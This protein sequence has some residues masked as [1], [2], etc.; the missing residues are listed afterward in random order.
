MYIEVGIVYIIGIM[1]FGVALYYVF[2]KKPV[3]IYNQMKPPLSTE[4]TDVKKYNH[5]TA[6]LM[7]AYGCVFIIEGIILSSEPMTCMVVGILTVMPG[8]VIVIAIYET[9]VIKKYKIKN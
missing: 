7:F 4:L 1:M 3:T 6:K 2:S 5:A 8:I 9:L